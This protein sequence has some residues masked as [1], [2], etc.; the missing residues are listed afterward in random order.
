MLIWLVPF[1]V[2]K[3]LFFP[4]PSEGVEAK[5]KY[6][7][8]IPPEDY[9]KENNFF[10]VIFGREDTLSDPNFIGKPY[11]VVAVGNFVFF[12]DTANGLVFS[13][14]IKTRYFRVLEFPIKLELPI[15]LAFSHKKRILFVS[16]SALKKVFGFDEKGRLVFAV[17]KKGEFKRPTGIAVDDKQERVY[18]VDT[19]DHRVKVYDFNGNFI[20]AFG[21]RGDKPGEFN[22]PS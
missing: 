19:F 7:G 1:A 11:G 9:E 15:G 16:D 13:Y 20:R 4:P 6:I 22:Y 14:N 5:I 17:G 10:D 3:E 12:T 2:G 18:V 8:Q 21:H